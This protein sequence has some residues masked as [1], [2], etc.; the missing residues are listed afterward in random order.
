M[1]NSNDHQTQPK[2]NGESPQ[3]SK[4]APTILGCTFLDLIFVLCITSCLVLLADWRKQNPGPSNWMR[5][6]ET[7]QI[8]AE[9]DTIAQAIRAGRGFS[10]PFHEQTGPTAWMPPVLVYLTAGLYCLTGDSRDIVVEIIITLNWLSISFGGLLVIR[11]ARRAGI[12]FLGMGV[13][14]LGL[15]ADFAELFQRTHDTWLILLVVNLTWLGAQRLPAVSV[16]DR[17]KQ[18]K[19]GFFGGF[20][21][22]CSPVA[23][24]AWALTTATQWWFRPEQAPPNSLQTKLTRFVT[25]LSI[26]ALAAIL[27]VTPWMIRNRV[28]M[29]KWIPVKS[30]AM[31]EIWQSQVLD[32]DGVLDSVSAWQHP[33]GSNSPQRQRYVEVGELAFIQERSEPTW[34]SIRSDPLDFVRRVINRF[35]AATMY[36]K[37]LVAS[38]ERMVW[39]LRYIRLYFPLPFLALLV[40]LWFK[41]APLS[42]AQLATVSIFLFYL[43]PY[44]A[45]SYYARYAAPLAMIKMLLILHAAETL[46]SVIWPISHVTSKPA[47]V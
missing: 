20:A 33:W 28:M 35:F 36:Y 22:L 32:D 12:A 41:T 38:D 31:Y 23:G 1:D 45:I 8:G 13:V 17:W 40:L 3:K 7:S 30:N 25:P 9:Y 24:I 42:S 6:D 14:T 27:V 15:L 47:E 44:I 34:N 2:T 4:P 39:P 10:D 11:Y 16:G 46:R 37:P 26:A 21:A 43:G 29:G 18:M 19:W 5:T